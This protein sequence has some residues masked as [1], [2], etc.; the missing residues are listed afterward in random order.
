VLPGALQVNFLVG[1]ES[2]LTSARTKF[3]ALHLI[4]AYMMTNMTIEENMT[5]H[6]SISTRCEAAAVVGCCFCVNDLREWPSA[7][8]HLVTVRQ[9]ASRPS[10]SF[11]FIRNEC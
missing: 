10:M 1:A 2:S 6:R 5:T 9:D 11:T 7:V 8:K 4:K 3:S